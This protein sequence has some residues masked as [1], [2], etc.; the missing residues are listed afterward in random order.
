M[1]L[2]LWTNSGT[3]NVSEGTVPAAADIDTTIQ[4]SMLPIGSIIAWQKSTTGVPATLKGGWVEC[5]GQTLSDASSPMN[6]QTIPDLNGNSAG[7]N[8]FLRGNSSSGGT[9]GA[10]GHTHNFPASGSSD[11]YDTYSTD[12]DI[13]RDSHTHTS[14]GDPANNS[15]PPY[16]N[17]VWIMRVK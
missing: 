1:T 2:G 17:T 4:E 10:E 7:N 14:T 15:L 5:N 12:A 9:G 8:R 6:G 11:G 16:V 13:A 3:V